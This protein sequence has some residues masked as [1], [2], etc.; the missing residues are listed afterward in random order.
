MPQEQDDNDNLG[1]WDADDTDEDEEKRRHL[2]SM[3]GL[4]VQCWTFI[5]TLLI[6]LLQKM[7]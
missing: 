4:S 6:T 3:W 2:L 7:G 5:L 1:M